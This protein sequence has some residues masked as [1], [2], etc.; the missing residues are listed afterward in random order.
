MG[1]LNFVSFSE[2]TPKQVWEAMDVRGLTISHFKSHLQMNRSRKH[3]QMI[4]VT[5]PHGRQNLGEADM[6]GDVSDVC[7][8]E[9]HKFTGSK[10]DP[11]EV[12]EDGE[13]DSLLFLSLFSSSSK[14]LKPTENI[15]VQEGKRK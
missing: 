11:I 13:V 9:E 10:D 15:I 3:E 4:Q 8:N 2:A 12:V 14:T 7:V 6:Y 5:H 1:V